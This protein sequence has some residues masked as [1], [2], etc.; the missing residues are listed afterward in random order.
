[1]TEEWRTLPRELGPY[2]VSDHGRVR[3]SSGL[4]LKQEIT[5]TGHR[6]VGLYPVPGRCK[7][8]SVH[9]LVAKVF[10][11][12]SD[13]DVLHWD[14]NPSNNFLE[15]L[16]YGTDQENW[17]DSVRN[18]SRE[19]RKSCIRNHPYPKRSD[20]SIKRRCYECELE[21]DRK[22]H[23]EK[24]ARGISKRDPRHG[25]YAGYRAGCRCLKCCDSNRDYKRVWAQNKRGKIRELSS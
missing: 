22:R 2:E 19:L 18:G 6:R 3:N 9:R 21:E 8:F 20:G 1:M 25:T 13:L 15:N 17:Y 5:R 24:I 7:H 12:E 16:R 4:V 10:I 23:F 14:D 11:G